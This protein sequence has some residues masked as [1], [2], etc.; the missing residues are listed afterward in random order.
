M[1]DCDTRLAP[2]STHPAQ[3]NSF[4]S[5]LGNPL[6]LSKCFICRDRALMC[7]ITQRFLYEVNVLKSLRINESNSRGRTPGGVWGFVGYSWTT[8]YC[9][10]Q[11]VVLC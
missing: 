3:T 1:V 11:N 4:R 6:S 2:S 9:P 5:L 10:N 8:G 7:Y